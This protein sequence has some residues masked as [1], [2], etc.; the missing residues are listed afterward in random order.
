MKKIFTLLLLGIMFLVVLTGCGEKSQKHVVSDLGKKME[1]IKGYKTNAVMTFMHGNKKQSYHAEIWY[2]KPSYYKVVLQD[3]KKE[4]KQ[5]IIR[6]K[7]GVFVLTPALNKSYRFESDWPNNRSQFYLYQSLAKD[8]LND[9][10][11]S[12]ESKDDKYIFKTKTNYPTKDLSNQKISLLKKDLAP[13]SVQVMDKDM[14]VIVDVNFK[15]FKMNP[16]F[17]KDDFDVKKN[18]TT[19]KLEEPTMAANNQEFK[20]SYPTVKLPNTKL[21]VMK[22]EVTS[23]QKKFVLKYKGDKAYT[24]IE[25]KSNAALTSSPV[26]AM[27]EPVNLGFTIGTMTDHSLSW[28]YDGMDYYLASSKLTDED[29]QNIARSTNGKLTK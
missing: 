26:M 11:A 27:G 8:I 24:L 17:G 29:M 19:A 14:N 13:K 18:M 6:N 20:V 5:M 12:F 10:S 22:P 28:S 4:N 9:E 1:E 15:D 2:K 7:D 23:D 25:T 16:S 3:N 21:S